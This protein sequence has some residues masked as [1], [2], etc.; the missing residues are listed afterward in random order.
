MPSTKITGYVVQERKSHGGP[1]ETMSR[2]F[3]RKETAIR[4]M[5]DHRRY[6]MTFYRVTARR[7]AA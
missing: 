6:G 7:S 2:K 1:W 5:H 4:W 3:G